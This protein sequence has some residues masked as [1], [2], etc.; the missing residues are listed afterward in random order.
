MSRLR[1]SDARFAPWLRISLAL[2]IAVLT[3]ACS[4]LLPA[5]EDS[6]VEQS[7]TGRFA[8]TVSLPE[9]PN[10]SHSGSFTLTQGLGLTQLDLSTPLGTVIA[11]ARSS[12]TG[13]I[14][15]TADGRRIDAAEPE[16]L[17]EQ[18]FGWR[19]PF[20]RLPDWLRG[21]PMTV[22]S[23]TSMPDGQKRPLLATEAGWQL[24]YEQWRDNQPDRVTIV[25][26][27]RVNLRLVLRRE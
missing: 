21:R 17:T 25:Y 4:T 8:L 23:Q 16:Q 3:V 14:L 13:A 27:E 19:V 18:L 20:Q 15:V 24:S 26:P 7:W 12:A 11:S 5:P 22:T 1:K 10:Q 2:A 6:R 9:Q